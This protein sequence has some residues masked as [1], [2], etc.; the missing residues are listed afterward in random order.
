VPTPDTYEGTREVGRR[1]EG[2]RQGTVGPRLMARTRGGGRREEGAATGPC[3][4][5]QGWGGMPG[6]Q[7]EG[8]G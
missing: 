5:A 2:H 3:A 7:G 1:E 4:R 8:Q 6:L